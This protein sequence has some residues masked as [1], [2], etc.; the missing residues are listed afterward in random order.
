MIEKMRQEFEEWC[1]KE[2]LWAHV[3][4]GLKAWQH[5]QAIIDAQDAKIVRL[6]DLLRTIQHDVKHGVYSKVIIALEEG[7]LI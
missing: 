6:E 2:E 5:Q 3:Q 1:S 4:E 7:K